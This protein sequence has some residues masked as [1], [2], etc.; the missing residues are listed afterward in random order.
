MTNPCAWFRPRPASFVGLGAVLLTVLAAGCGQGDRIE[1]YTVEKSAASAEDP[2]ISSPHPDGTSAPGAGSEAGPTDVAEAVAQRLLGAILPRGRQFWF[3][4]AVGA[5]EALAPHAERFAALIESIR[6]GEEA[7]APP[8]WKLPQGWTQ[9]PA[10]GMRLA[11]IKLDPDDPALEIS[12]IPLPL[13]G[14]DAEAYVL[15]NVNRWRAQVGLGPITPKQ[16]AEETSSVELDGH[17]ATIVDFTGKA[18]PG[19]MRPPAM[20]PAGMRPGAGDPDGN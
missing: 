4:K 20:G 12:V 13:M 1:K 19:G 11:T 18:V 14:G 5:P 9:E 7:D 6:F 16:L 17:K 15:N 3:F 8:T 10:S 2:P